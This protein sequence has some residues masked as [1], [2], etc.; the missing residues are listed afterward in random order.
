MAGDSARIANSECVG[1]HRAA[2]EQAK[3]PACQC[4]AR[5]RQQATAAAMPSCR[6]EARAPGRRCGTW[7]VPQRFR[8]MAPRRLR[9]R[10]AAAVRRLAAGQMCRRGAGRGRPDTPGPARSAHV[11]RPG[12]YCARPWRPAPARHGTTRPVPSRECC[13][14][15]TARL[16][17]VRGEQ[18]IAA[19]APSTPARRTHGRPGPRQT[20]SDRRSARAE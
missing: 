20:V 16:A 9:P 1:P 8:C 12:R 6:G 15:P 19:A 13:L 14:P 3:P 5:L 11:C 7:T 18:R 10:A 2:A 4:W 17:C